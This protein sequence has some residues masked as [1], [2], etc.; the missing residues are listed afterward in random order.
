MPFSIDSNDEYDTAFANKDRNIKLELFNLLHQI[1]TS[2]N[3]SS[4]SFVH[5]LNENDESYFFSTQDGKSF[6]TFELQFFAKIQ[7]VACYCE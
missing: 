7:F 3:P 1:V 6:I 4:L 2:E 5:K